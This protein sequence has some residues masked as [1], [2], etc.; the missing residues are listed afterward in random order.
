VKKLVIN[1]VF[2]IACVSTDAG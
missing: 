1:V 2:F